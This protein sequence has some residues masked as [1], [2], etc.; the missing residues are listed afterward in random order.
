MFTATLFTA[1]KTWK[2]RKCPSTE[3]KKMC[4]MHTTEYYSATQKN[5]I[6]AF[7]ATWMDLKI[8]IVNEITQ[9]KKYPMTSLIYR[10]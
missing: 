8:V 10:S 9:T 5:E 3:I 2:R 6:M 1:A 4:C 7:S